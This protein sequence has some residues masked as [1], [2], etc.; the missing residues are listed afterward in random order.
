MKVRRH[1]TSLSG[2]RI[3][4]VQGPWLWQACEFCR[5]RCV[6]WLGAELSLE[7]EGQLVRSSTGCVVELWSQLG[8]ISHQ[9][10]ACGSRIEHTAPFAWNLR[11]NCTN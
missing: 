4:E 5:G 8:D 7:T 10:C 11:N 2:F 9:S 3:Q 6:E 1:S